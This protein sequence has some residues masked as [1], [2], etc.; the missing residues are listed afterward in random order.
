MVAEHERSRSGSTGCGYVS[1][2]AKQ[3]QCTKTGELDDCWER[4]QRG[5]EV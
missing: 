1:K 5:K 3:R 4:R 2:E